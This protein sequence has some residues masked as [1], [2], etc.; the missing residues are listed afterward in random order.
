MSRKRSK[1]VKKQTKRAKKDY[2]T[3][4]VKK[5]RHSLGIAAKYLGKGTRWKE[6]YKL[7]KST[8]EKAAK[9]PGLQI[10]S[11]RTLDLAETTLKLPK[12]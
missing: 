10:F 9:S 2:K 3:H 12:K 8:I 11:Q 7:N 6:I 1:T 5:W 4:I